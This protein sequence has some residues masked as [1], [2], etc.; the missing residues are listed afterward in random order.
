MQTL[1]PHEPTQPLK[2]GWPLPKPSL[3]QVEEPEAL[4][5]HTWRAVVGKPRHLAPAEKHLQK[6]GFHDH[7]LE[8]S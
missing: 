1:C 3:F 4:Q 5:G 2:L 7:A 6:V 8:F